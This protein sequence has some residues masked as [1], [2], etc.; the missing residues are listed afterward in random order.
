MKS[1]PI[2]LR[3]RIVLF[4]E[5]GGKQKEA[6]KVFKVSVATVHNLIKKARLGDSLAPKPLSRTFR[7]I[8]PVELAAFFEKNPDAPL[9]A[10]K[11]V[12]GVTE[13]GIHRA[14]KK[15]K[16]TLKKRSPST[17]SKTKNTGKSSY[18]SLIR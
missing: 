18:H 13:S 7:K 5:E 4:V 3:E 10:A 11:S 17:P 6:A 9:K 14:L 12:F 2:E 16:F 1:F 15:I 8:D